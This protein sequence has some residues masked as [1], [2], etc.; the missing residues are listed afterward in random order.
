MPIDAD[1]IMIHSVEF[2]QLELAPQRA[3]E[4]SDELQSLVDSA[5]A[6]SEMSVFDDDPA[7]FLCMLW[8]LRDQTRW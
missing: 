3:S 8:A 7:Q 4:L 6:A 2:H 1:L 5:F